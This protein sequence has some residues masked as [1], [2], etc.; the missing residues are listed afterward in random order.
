MLPGPG[1]GAALSD[2][3]IG[4][5]ASTGPSGEPTPADLAHLVVGSAAERKLAAGAAPEIVLPEDMLP[6]A[7]EE[8]IS[9]REGLRSYGS[10]AFVV[11]AI[12]VTLDNLQ[13][14][15]LA[16][17][18]P[19]I[20]SSFHVSTGAITFVA[21]I[22]GGFLVLGI[23]P[24][25]WLADRYR[26]API[27]GWA[28]F[29]FG[30]MV[31]VSGLAVN[32]FVFFLARFG[33]GISQSSTQS[34]HG[35]L[36]ADTY[37][38]S[39]R[40]RLYAGMGM[41][42]GGATAL[43]PV[44]V[45]FIA[46]AVG[47]PNGW[48]W[49]FY[50][51]AIPIV[52]IAGF[53]FRIKEPPRGQ[54]EKKD[55]LGEVI[56]DAQPASPSLEAAFE[57]IMR[58]RT[59]KMVLIAFSA[60][61]FGLFTG[62]VLGNLWLKQHF[63]L[64]AFQRGL[65]VT[66]G[67]V[68]VLISLPLVGRYYDRLYRKDPARA[69]SLIGKVVLPCAVLIPIQYFMPNAVLWAIFSIP[70]AILLLTGFSM[71]AP[72]LQS[73]APY[74]L[75]GL[76][77]AVGGIYVFF[78]GAT[79]GAVLAALLDSVVGIRATVLIIMIPSTIFG[80]IMIIRSAHFIRNDLS[81][82]VV[83]LQEEQ[84]EHKRQEDDP[85]QIPVLQLSN[86][87]F[88]YGHVQILFG[89][90]FEVKRGEVLALLG[91]NGAGKSTALNVAAGLEIAS[92]G[93]VR[94]NGRDIT[95]TTPEQRSRLGIHLLPGGKG[96]FGP[97]TVAENLEMGG[98]VY[99]SDRAELRRRTERVYELFPA[100]KDRR[101]E[102]ADALSGGQ[103]QMLA[104]AIAMLHDPAVLMIDELSLG[105]APIIVQELIEVVDGLKREGVTLIIVEQSLNVAAAIADRAVFL[106]K[107]RVRFEGQIRDL[108][109]RDDL[110]R[111]VFLGGQEDA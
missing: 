3:T 62:P 41:A 29:V 90:N 4:G 2:P 27:I 75:R 106:E 15:G 46:T 70:S 25:G 47:G 108:M 33:A 11:L 10:R 80:S 98:F 34:V 7:G 24:M 49:A 23:V 104:L 26:R 50:I 19:N 22:A 55:V 18:A 40:G 105:L 30:L 13:S 87:D 109:E 32:I 78:V 54:F 16:T 72:V 91:T 82:V 6:G 42:L 71:I 5:L 35:S 68:G 76:V 39:M 57:R 20:Q 110:A 60:I 99:R 85:D 37:P 95:Y 14:S 77:G 83:E 97:M 102:R 101:G 31:F 66:I 48:R 53:A 38:I 51:L 45:G 9:L 59:I 88:S 96:V 94:L 12:I 1:I 81:L 17:L 52:L 73:V 44:L 93:A 69:L 74:R 89:V 8:Q 92:R 28:T 21:G 67:N 36:L 111:A 103:Q 79:G 56:T 65:I 100:I 63:G 64:D 58:I 61:G 107:G 86:V 43:S 84:E